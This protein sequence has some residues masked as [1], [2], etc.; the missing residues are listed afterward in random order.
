MRNYLFIA[1]GLFAAS[2][3][4]SAPVNAQQVTKQDVDGVTNFRRLETTVACAGA[5]K[6]E[7]PFPSSRNGFR[8]DHQFSRSWR[9]GANVEAR[10]RGRESGRHGLSHVPFNGQM[11][12]PAAAESFSNAI[13]SKGADPAF[14]HC[15]EGIVPRRCG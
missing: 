11:P 8:L 6:P 13:T 5:M 7:A 10:G 1:A 9:A 12:D 2:F 15:A 4:A 3:I 14:I